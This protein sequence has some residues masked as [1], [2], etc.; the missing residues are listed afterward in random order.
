MS[1]FIFTLLR[2]VRSET[3]ES[4][5]PYVLP[6]WANLTQKIVKTDGP[7]VKNITLLFWFDN[8]NYLTKVTFK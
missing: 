1:L 5:L 2:Q 6:I 3:L 4:R 7:G 8:K